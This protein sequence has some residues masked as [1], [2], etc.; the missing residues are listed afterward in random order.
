MATLV[1]SEGHGTEM[2]LI[3]LGI[4]KMHC[5]MQFNLVILY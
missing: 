4:T 2:N 5:K 3:Y 1:R